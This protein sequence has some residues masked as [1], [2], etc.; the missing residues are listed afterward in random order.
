MK[1]INLGSGQIEKMVGAGPDRFQIQNVYFDVAKGHLVA[2]NGIGLVL[3]RVIAE[4]GETTGWITPESLGA[5]RKAVQKTPKYVEESRSKVGLK[6]LPAS[7]IVTDWQ[8]KEEVF[9]RPEFRGGFANYEVVIPKNPGGTP[10]FTLDFDQLKLIVASLGYVDTLNG[11]SKM[12]A[13][14]PSEE[15][16][17]PCLVKTSMEGPIA[18]IMPI[19]AKDEK[20]GWLTTIKQVD[21]RFREKVRAL[22]AAIMRAEELC[23]ATDEEA[24]EKMPAV[25][26]PIVTLK[27]GVLRGGMQVA[28]GSE[29]VGG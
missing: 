17:G 16:G 20:T 2:T 8:G 11:R 24:E 9:V 26:G 29:A 18:I 3:S 5:Y 28:A 25:A 27:A 1:F 21:K 12:I 6:A 10:G 15:P 7:L 14:F 13:V 19:K 4:D 23:G 22:N